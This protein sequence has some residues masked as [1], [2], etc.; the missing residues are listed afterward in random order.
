[1]NSNSSFNPS[2]SANIPA[3]LQ[4]LHQWLVWKS[5]P[6]IGQENKFTKVPY[7]LR[8]ALP[9]D[10]TSADTWTTFDQVVQATGYD[11]IGFAINQ[12]IGLLLIDLDDC[13]VDGVVQ[14]WVEELIQICDT[15][16]EYSPSGLGFHLILKGQKLVDKTRFHHNQAILDHYRRCLS[17]AKGNQ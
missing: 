12:P 6:R 2:L 15:Y 4:N 16:T 8:T 10:A 11:G 14:A 1:M 13:I 17:R 9:S 5:Q 3:R 7:N